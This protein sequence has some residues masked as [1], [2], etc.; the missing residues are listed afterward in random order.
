MSSSMM[1]TSLGFWPL[2]YSCCSLNLPTGV[3][4][5]FS[6]LACC[7][8]IGCKIKILDMISTGNIML[9]RRSTSVKPIYEARV[10]R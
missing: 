3:Y 7:D 10:S 4:L 2:Y 6:N 1:D 9:G 5:M 8:Q